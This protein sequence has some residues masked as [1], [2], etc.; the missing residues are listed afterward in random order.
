MLRIIVV[1]L[2]LLG[3]SADDASVVVDEGDFHEALSELVPSLSAQELHRYASIERQFAETSAKVY[4]VH[5]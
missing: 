4:G 5:A 2:I 1:A 3:V